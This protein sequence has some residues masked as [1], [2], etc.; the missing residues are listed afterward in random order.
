M[1]ITKN[2]KNI[3]E[4]SHSLRNHSL[5]IISSD[6]SVETLYKILSKNPLLINQKDNKGETLLS[7]S[8]ERNKQDI[9]DLILT[10]PIL[11]LDYQNK[12]GNSYLH[13]AVQFER[14]EMIKELIEKGIS[15]NIQNNEGNTPLH[16]AYYT[17]NKKII[18]YLI[19]NNIDYTIKNNNGEIAEQNS[20]INYES[21]NFEDNP[22]MNDNI[23]NDSEINIDNYSLN[24]NEN[25]DS[26]INESIKIEWS[27][28]NLM[29]K[30][31]HFNLSIPNNNCTSIENLKSYQ[32]INIKKKE[33]NNTDDTKSNSPK[34][35]NS[36]KQN[37]NNN[38]YIENKPNYF[39]ISS[40]M[41]NQRYENNDNDNINNNYN[42]GEDEDL[43]NINFNRVEKMK[44]FNTTN[45][46]HPKNI[47]TRKNSS[48]TANS[49]LILIKPKIELNDNFR[50]SSPYHKNNKEINDNLKKNESK[51]ISSSQ[52]MKYS[53]QHIHTNPNPQ[54]STIINNKNIHSN[55]IESS[56][57]NQD[58]ILFL[59]SINLVKYYKNF[60]SNG[61]D[62]IKL[63]INQTKTDLGITEN[64]LKEAGI[65]SSGDR[66]KIIIKV[67]ELAGNFSYQIPKEV[68]YTCDNFDNIEKD[69]NISKLNNWLKEINVET[70]LS[71]FI[72][73]GYHSLELLL[74]QLESKEPLSVEK[75]KN[76]LG[77]DI[78]GFRQ[79][80]Y[81]KLKDDR[82]KLIGRLKKNLIITEQRNND[83]CHDCHIF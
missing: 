79:R 52:L 19:Q 30:N 17:R 45:L 44:R 48:I 69:K 16:L 54:T 49:N 18:N 71:N 28:S 59:Q 82:R 78:I 50:F 1:N 43:V 33:E 62:D 80:I 11:D 24:K 77:I 2:K 4:S 5:I 55:I 13:I 6:Y 32:M 15:L 40:S 26:E 73:N 36:L 25:D 23:M 14:E 46:F 38:I 41:E 35:I 22:L 66:A 61:F 75:L 56:N 53:I 63:I 34:Y 81:N 10:S 29:K 83:I 57:N 39:N 70:L 27:G 74:I 9:F 37:E 31:R 64:N 68:Y 42:I 12:E 7:Y 20:I 58:L 21:N 8:I 51:K 3:P 67:Q 72:S 47:N 76:D 60:I 65:F